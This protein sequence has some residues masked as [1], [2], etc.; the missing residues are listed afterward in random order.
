MGELMN[1]TK[2]LNPQGKL[3]EYAKQVQKKEP[4]ALEYFKKGVDAITPVV[5]GS[6]GGVAKG[7]GGTLDDIGGVVKKILPDYATYE[8]QQAS[9]GRKP[10][11]IRNEVANLQ[12]KFVDK[13]KLSKEQL[14]NYNKAE[15]TGEFLGNAAS[16]IV[17]YGIA[18]EA[19]KG[20]TL[21]S[22]LSAKAPT[23]AAIASN[24]AKGQIADTLISTI[25]NISKDIDSGKNASDV[26]KNALADEGINLALNTVFSG[27]ENSKLIRQAISDFNAKKITQKQLE[28]T[29]KN[30]VDTQA[31][32]E[33]KRY[34]QSQSDLLNRQNINDFKSGK[35]TQE[36]FLQRQNEIYQTGID[37]G[38]AMKADIS[39]N[40]N[41]NGEQLQIPLNKNPELLQPQP[42]NS[43][44]FKVDETGKVYEYDPINDIYTPTKTNLGEVKQGTSASI[45]ANSEFP[46]P[47]TTP[48][49]AK[50]NKSGT[51]IDI[52]TPKSEWKSTK[53]ADTI[54]ID[55]EEAARLFT[56]DVKKVNLID[57]FRT[58]QKVLEK[59]G[60]GKEAD[61]LLKG[62]NDYLDELPKEIDKVTK[63]W[64]RVGESKESSQK[65]FQYLDGRRTLD[66]LSQSE[67]SVSKEIKQ[68]LSDWADRLKLPKSKRVS[69]YIT[70]IFEQD[71]IK[72]DFDPAIAKLITDKPAGS[73]YDPFVQQRLGKNG[74]VEDVFRA[75]DA[76]VKRG[77]RKANMDPA[78]EA[79]KKASDG[80]QPL[81]NMKYLTKLT[82]GINMRPTNVDNLIDNT[83][84]QMSAIGYKLGTRPFTQISKNARQMVYRGTLGANVGSAVRNLTQGV[85]TFS[86]LGTKWTLKGYSD[87]LKNWNADELAKSG[88]LRDSFVQDRTLSATKKAVEKLDKGLFYLFENVEKINRGAAY[89]GAKSR[90]LSKGL[91]ESEA[92]KQGVEAARK[93]QFTFGSVDTP[94]ALQSDIAKTLL[95][96]QSFNIKQAEFL[97]GK[98]K[99]KEWAGLAR[100]IGANL[101]IISTIGQL[102]GLDY[103]DAV[104]FYGVLTGESKIGQTPAVK[105]AE[106]IYGAAVGTPDKYGNIE[107]NVLKRFETVAKNDL[108]AFVPG[109][110]QAKKTFQGLQSV[111]K[112][113]SYNDNGKLQ[114]AIPNTAGNTVRSALFGKSNL[115]EAQ[116]YFSSKNTPLSEFQTKAYK[117]AID[118]GVKET[119]FY[120][121]AQGIKDLKPEAGRK[122]V[123]S[124]QKRKYLATLFKGKKLKLM[125]DLLVDTDKG[126]ERMGIK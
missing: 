37:S 111:S 101:L 119:D 36:Q 117:Y 112:S 82:G 7:L 91:N 11:N 88:V 53:A 10:L 28:E 104:P 6:V 2:Q 30:E 114:Y 92:I 47:V 125:S 74:Y 55:G 118:N 9:E 17:P 29:V 68:Y 76:Y 43:K 110:V 64:K 46:D 52:E 24:A 25:P 40:I 26:I 77:V 97:A 1:Y 105:A 96:F 83:L 106:D 35:I 51:N 89:Y 57:Y 66:T 3:T 99:N 15:N 14:T 62:N 93:T 44:S 23:I 69:N 18:N 80:F 102:I 122:G 71:F 4:T 103:T 59:I 34:S 21:F 113:G 19:L 5:V 48:K 90:A 32:A 115:P 42:N 75:L 73:V 58:P 123:T 54:D 16:M 100:Y 61:M 63:W 72:K 126:K 45:N 41:A 87:M 60:L 121:A 49:A 98:I 12:N 33:L 31:K 107:P 67:Q 27:V 70:H 13:S 109:G 86:E 65:I 20:V 84:K 38:K 79:L 94:V 22:K 108:P 116:S 124:V 39:G 78:L 85:N 81:E 50:F 120:N 95:Q 56:K 8:A